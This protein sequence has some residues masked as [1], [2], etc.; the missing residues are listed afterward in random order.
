MSIEDLHDIAKKLHSVDQAR[1]MS[2]LEDD[3]VKFSRKLV[4]DLVRYVDHL[5]QRIAALEQKP[6]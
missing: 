5:E 4:I 6:R 1:R 3:S 2:A